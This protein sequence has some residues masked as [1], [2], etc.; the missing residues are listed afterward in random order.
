MNKD[1]FVIGLVVVS[2]LFV[3]GV[4]NTQAQ[5]ISN[6]TVDT[7]ETWIFWEWDKNVTIGE[8][9]IFI[10]GISIGYTPFNYSIISNLE[11]NEQ[12][13]IGIWARNGTEELYT[14]CERTDYPFT[15]IYLIILLLIVLVVI[16]YLYPIF[17]LLSWIPALALVIIICENLADFWILFF[18]AFFMVG[19]SLVFWK[20]LSSGK[21]R[22]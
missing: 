12:H 2:F 3:V 9:N 5:Y 21:G 7:G 10:D 19:S 14:A 22:I 15:K 16:A 18:V 4:V 20:S 11:P 8:L 17:A 1:F 13:C 6:I